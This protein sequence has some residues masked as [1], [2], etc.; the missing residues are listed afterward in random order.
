MTIKK[1]KSQATEQEKILEM[2]NLTKDVLP[3]CRK[4]SYSSTVSK[5]ATK[6]EDRQ[7]I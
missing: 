4:S 2:T 3:E 7:N 5:Q 6:F 1:M